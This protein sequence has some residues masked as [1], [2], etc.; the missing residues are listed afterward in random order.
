MSTRNC[1][2]QRACA[3]PELALV[4]VSGE[5]RIKF[6]QGQ[7]TNDV[8]KLDLGMLMTAGWCSPKGRLLSAPRLFVD[9]EAVGMLIDAGSADKLIQRLRMYVLRSKVIIERDCSRKAA[10][11]LGPVPELPEG[12][13]VFTQSCMAQ[14]VQIGLAAPAGRSLAIVPAE[15]ELEADSSSYWAA[16]AAAGDPWIF[17]PAA[18]Q[19]VP[20]AVNLEL[21]GGVS[22]TK[23]CYTGQEIVSRVE[24]IGK[25]P[26]RGALAVAEGEAA[27][28]PMTEIADGAGSPVGVVVYAAA[29][30]GKTA[31]FVQLPNELLQTSKPLSAAG[32]TL[33]LMPLPYGYER[34]H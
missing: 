12:S 13:L 34:L 11:I 15:L 1:T 10:G 24:H 2:A 5:D 20:Q 22:F 18:A 25:T 31:A 17:G 28:A 29:I 30:N 6:L 23:G 4:R 27:L 14:S 33:M 26:R 7:L 32:R 19:C 16:S 9:G 3:L 8:T 21:A